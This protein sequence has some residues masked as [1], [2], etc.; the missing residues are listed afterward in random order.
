VPYAY[1]SVPVVVTSVAPSQGPASGRNTVTLTGSSLTLAQSVAFDATLAV[2]TVFSDTKI[3]AIAPPGAA[4]SV[5]VTVT[6]PG[7]TGTGLAYA[8][9]PPP[10]I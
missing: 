7:G 5:P 2:F 4:L 8:R 10:Q 3:I 1:T 6:T 9:I